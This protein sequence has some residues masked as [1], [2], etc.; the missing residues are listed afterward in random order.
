MS[1]I[2]IIVPVYNVE[3]YLE[4]CVN[5]LVNQT[6]KDIEI[7]LVDDGS[8]DSSGEM[9]ERYAQQDDRIIVLHQVNQGQSAARNRGVER[10]SGEYILF[11]DSDD[12]I[13]LDACE[14][15]ILEA[16]KTGADIVTGDILNEADKLKNEENFRKLA[17]EN[18]AIKGTEYL[19][20][21]LQ[22]NAYDIVPWIRIVR[23][24]Y[25]EQNGIQFKEGCYYEDQLYTLQLLTSGCTVCKIRFP[26]YYYRMDRQ[27]STTNLAQLKKGTDFISVLTDMV[28][29][30]NNYNGD[31]SE[32]ESMQ[33]V[34]GMG[35]YHL[36]AVWLNMNDTDKKTIVKLLKDNALIQN[37][38]SKLS[39]INSQTEKRVKTF[40]QNPNLLKWERKLKLCIKKI[41]K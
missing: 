24:K 37:S 38:F 13:T 30:V 34:L 23:K 8:T 6:F 28:T 14:A 33:V 11:V 2:S 21:A 29:Y 12:Y 10:S 7:I 41:V 19:K 32:I 16:E 39:F 25:L 15:L 3:N 5:S 20:M 36:S 22:A 27:G 40:I 31:D 26:F 1:K 18:V 9:C 4:E 17:K 35:Y